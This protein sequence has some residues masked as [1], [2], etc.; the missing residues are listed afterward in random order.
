MHFIKIYSQGQDIEFHIDF[1]L[2]PPREYIDL[3]VAN[4]VVLKL[5][6]HKHTVY[7]DRKIGVNKA[8]IFSSSMIKS[9]NM[10]IILNKCVCDQAA[11]GKI[12]KLT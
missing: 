1:L 11:M 7:P 6:G 2:H 3:L 12:L 10:P 5:E 8:R 4:I 9:S